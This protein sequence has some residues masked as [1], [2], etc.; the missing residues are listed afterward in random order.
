MKIN[1]IKI[2]SYGKLKNK[3]INLKNNI[4]II[5]GKNESGKS[6][7][8][9]FILNI[10]YGTSKNKKGRDIS[11]FE[12]YKPWD[13][14]E[15][16]GKLSYELDNKNKYEI[17]REFNKKNPTI[18]NEK[19]ED[20]T[21]EFNI[22]KN[23]GSEFFYEQTQINEEMFL[24][25]SIAMQQEVKIGRDAQSTLI[26]RLSNLLGTGEDNVSYKKAIE[27]LN[28]K[29]LDEIG[30]ERSREKPI[31][32]LEKN[33]EKNKNEINELKKYEN[34]LYEIEEEKNKIK[35]NIEKNK[36]KNNLLKEIK[37]IKD[38]N[39]IENEKIKIKEKINE[40]NKNK[41]EEIKNKI[42][43]KEQEYSEKNNDKKYLDKKYEKNKL[44]NKLNIFLIILILIN[45]L[46]II[47][48]PKIIN[49]LIIKYIF[50]LTVPMYLIFCIFLKN[51]L[52]KKLRNLEKNKRE[53]LEKIENEKNNLINEKKIIEKNWQEINNEIN[54]IKTENN[55]KNNLEEYKLLN[56]YKNE[57]DEEEINNLLDSEKIEEEININEYKLNNDKLEINKLEIKKD[58]IEP[59][60]ENL[61]KLEEELIAYEEQHENLQKINMSIELTKK[62]LG[63]AYERMKN[64][65]SPIFTEKLSKNIAKIT[66]NKYTNLYFSDDQGLTIEL[67]NG[68]YIPADRLSIG[69]IDQLYLSLRLAMLDEISNEK[70]PIILDEAFAYFD[71]DRLK[72]ILIYLTSEFKDRQ[73]IILTCTK[74]EKEIL[75]REKIKYNEVIL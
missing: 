57:L 40:E 38:K 75:D 20:I 44:N 5:Y 3:E 29:Q 21:K 64:S 17:Y 27:K 54:K 68:N 73:I 42:E 2:N 41:I 60:L 49:N 31:N 61:S 30:T 72:N 43:I 10:F 70:V 59:Q 8:L 66:K 65:V 1:K 16:S 62:L 12:K 22:D 11:D 52:N 47:F 55:S 67:D 63:N 74:R 26:Q 51:K 69:T 50:L 33:I 58:N 25:T 28:K 23:K 37:K 7:L 9:K 56:K 35:N 4:N 13:S 36:I 15:F 34:I 6:T 18:F 14:E 71:N 53:E 48:I 24:A 32:I 45:I 19:G 46:W 39:N